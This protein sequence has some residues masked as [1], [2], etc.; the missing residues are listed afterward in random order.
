MRLIPLYVGLGGGIGALV[1]FAI[2]GWA[3]TW[4]GG[5]VPWGT[6]A[7]NL[8]G[9]TLLGI[10]LGVFGRVQFSPRL[11]ALLTAGFCGG[12]TTFSTF[13]YQVVALVSGGSYTTAAAYAAGSITVCTFGV[14]VGH[15]VAAARG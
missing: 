3:L 10:L 14:A 2:E 13:S 4:T 8:I 1:R 11:R 15:A 5:I 7:V 12:M 6:L 9:S